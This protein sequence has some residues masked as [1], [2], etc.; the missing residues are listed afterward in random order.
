MGRIIESGKI[1][2]CR[3]SC[4]NRESKTEGEAR[5]CSQKKTGGLAGVPPVERLGLI[6]GEGRAT[7]LRRRE[8]DPQKS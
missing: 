3:A 5:G 2:V 6:V 8:S 1:P 4:D 7:V